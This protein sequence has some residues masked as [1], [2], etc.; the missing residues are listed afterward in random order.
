[1]STHLWRNLRTE[2]N[3][4]SFGGTWAS[5]W[6]CHQG[7]RWTWTSQQINSVTSVNGL[8]ALLDCGQS[9]PGVAWPLLVAPCPGAS[10]QTVLLCFFFSFVSEMLAKELSLPNWDRRCIYFNSSSMNSRLSLGTSFCFQPWTVADLMANQQPESA[11]AISAAKPSRF[12]WTQFLGQKFFFFFFCS[13]RIL[14]KQQH[15]CWEYKI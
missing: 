9:V 15:K 6:T 10:L 8:A 11:A 7:W 12:S 1:M 13:F 14:G 4:P 2:G 5:K 3:L